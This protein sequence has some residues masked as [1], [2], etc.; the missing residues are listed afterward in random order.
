[1]NG[2][3]TAPKWWP[4]APAFAQLLAELG[5]H[6]IVVGDLKG[7][8]YPESDHIHVL[9]TGTWSIR[10]SIAFSMHADAVVGQ[11]TGLMN[12]LALEAVPKLVMLS[13]STAENLTRDWQA[14]A[15]L[16]GAVPC[17][18]C[19]QLHYTFEHCQEHVET[20]TAMCQ[21]SIAPGTVWDAVLASYRGR[22]TVNRILA[23]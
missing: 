17:Y 13:H 22:E 8:E 2:G 15:T 16:A 11:E 20:G 18:P 7:L 19:H 1:M 21:Y 10:Q 4:Y 5:I 9:G 23:A 12:A 6:V 14:C 3:S